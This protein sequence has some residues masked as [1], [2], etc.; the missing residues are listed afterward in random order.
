[1]HKALDI[2]ASAPRAVVW[3]SQSGIVVLKDRYV[4]SGNTIII[5]HGWGILSMYF[6]LET[7]ANIEAGQKI[8]K[9]NPIGTMGK[10]GYAGGYHLHWEM[11]VGNVAIDPMQW[12]MMLNHL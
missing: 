12:I 7:Y 1:M 2:V 4:H 11:R 10:T 3:A 6:H 5:D 8:R 9:G